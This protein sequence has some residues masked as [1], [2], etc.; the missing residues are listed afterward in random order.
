M[1]V[2]WPEANNF[3]VGVQLFISF[4]KRGNQ[5]STVHGRRC[6]GKIIIAVD[7]F[8][9]CFLFELSSPQNLF[10]PECKIVFR[11]KYGILNWIAGNF[12]AA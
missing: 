9:I 11:G 10:Y 4:W 7:K 1:S 5:T 2:R 8:L 3:I 6:I 12:P